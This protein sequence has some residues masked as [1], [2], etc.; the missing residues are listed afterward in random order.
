MSKIHS[1]VNLKSFLHFIV[2][3]L[4]STPFHSFAQL[5]APNNDG[6]AMGH[7]HFQASDIEASNE[8]WEDLGATS[9]QNGP[10][11]MYAIPGVFILVRE[12]EP[13]NGSD[14][15]MIIHVGF[16]VPNVNAAYD[17]WISS[18][19]DVERGGF[20][21]QLWVN[22]PDGLLIEILENTEINTPIQ[23]HHIHWETP[24]IEAMQNWYYEMFGAVPG[25]R[26][27]F[28]AGDIP[29]VNLTFNQAETPVMPTQ[30]TVLDHIGFEVSDLQATIAKLEAAGVT[31]DLGYR[32]IP[33]ANLAIAFLTDPWGTY[34]E[35]TQGLE[36][37]D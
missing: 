33:A 37:Q 26:A 25:M 31:M 7:L 4:F 28:Q 16:H 11:S 5:A 13:S 14:G 21:G 29:G 23:M 17:R 3:L 12:A 10:L 19:I 30:G 36:P 1:V 2:A 34:I 15:T 24:D 9:I 8:F 20:P 35:L 6:V 32:E 18:G 27:I 22:G